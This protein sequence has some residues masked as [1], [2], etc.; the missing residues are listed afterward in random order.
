MYVPTKHNSDEVYNFQH[1]RTESCDQAAKDACFTLNMFKIK[2]NIFEENL[3]HGSSS[4]FKCWDSPARAVINDTK[5]LPNLQSALVG[6]HD[7]NLV[8]PMQA[9]CLDDWQQKALQ[10]NMSMPIQGVDSQSIYASDPFVIASDV[11]VNNSVE[12]KPIERGSNSMDL[13]WTEMDETR[14]VSQMDQNPLSKSINLGTFQNFGLTGSFEV[15]DEG[16]NRNSDGLDVQKNRES[17]FNIAQT[18][19]SGSTLSLGYQN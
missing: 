17:Q 16:F 6:D 14:F 19:N 2:T 11:N 18:V 4:D 3:A 13:G 8:E 1:L 12:L 9:L 15:H 10:R 5:S 7:L